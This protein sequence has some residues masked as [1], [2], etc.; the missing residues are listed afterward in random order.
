MLG[1]I[2]K[3]IN[4]ENEPTENNSQ[5][6]HLHPTIIY[7]YPYDPYIVNV[8]TSFHT[9]DVF[10]VGNPMSSN[11][12]IFMRDVKIPMNITMVQIGFE[13]DSL[14]M[15]G[16]NLDAFFQDAK[17]SNKYISNEVFLQSKANLTIPNNP[18][19]EDDQTILIFWKPINNFN[20]TWNHDKFSMQ[21]IY[22]AWVFQ[23]AKTNKAIQNQ[24]AETKRTNDITTGLTYVIVAFIPIGLVAEFWIEYII[25]NHFYRKE[26]SCK[27]KE[28]IES[29][30]KK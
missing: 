1:A 2:I 30:D 18:A 3:V 29:K 24:I 8:T 19:S 11:I 14:W 27:D 9:D 26:P 22:P 25:E 7:S 28:K 4:A 17:N 20:G 13:P 5:T 16:K 23:Q 10:A 6:I 15:N 21:K 12:V